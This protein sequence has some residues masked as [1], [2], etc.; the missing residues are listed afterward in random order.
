MFWTIWLMTFS[1]P[2][3]FAGSSGVNVAG[4]GTVKLGPSV[5]GLPQGISQSSTHVFCVVVVVV[6]WDVSATDAGMTEGGMTEAG[7]TDVDWSTW[8]RFST[9]TQSLGDDILSRSVEYFVMLELGFSEKK[10]KHKTTL[11]HKRPGAS[12]RF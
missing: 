6:V 12:N 7:M 3:S 5:T 4:V 9:L 2:W 10:T 1:R 8:I 11:I